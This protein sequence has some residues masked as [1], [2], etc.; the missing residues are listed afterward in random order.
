MATWAQFEAAKPTLAAAGRR[1]LY[2]AETG[3]ALLATVRGD[4]PPRIHPIWVGIAGGR[5][6]AFILKSAKRVDLERDGRYA[7]HTHIDPTSPSEFSVRG[8]A[9]M[10]DALAARSEVGGGWYF[11]VDDSY[12]LFEFNIEAAILG[13]RDDADE[14]PPRYQTWTAA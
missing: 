12:E 7:L 14:W 9:R 13:V 1:L 3:E 10:V 4:D 11:E 2:R 8:R 5:L 6:Y